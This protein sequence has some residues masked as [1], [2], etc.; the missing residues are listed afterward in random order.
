[1]NRPCAT[2]L[3]ILLAALLL[4]S[5]SCT[6]TSAVAQTMGD[7]PSVRDARAI[8]SGTRIQVALRENVS[9]ETAAVGDAWR[10]VLGPA[11]DP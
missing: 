9:S 6:E 1:M 11:C 5:S 3:A 4:T 2:L 8:V 10:V 7:T